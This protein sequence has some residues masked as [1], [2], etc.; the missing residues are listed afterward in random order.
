MSMTVS[1]SNGR[2][3]ILHDVRLEISKNVDEGL[4][5]NDVVFIDKLAKFGH[6]VTAYT[7]AKFQPYID[8]F[9]IGK[10]NCRQIHET[11]TEH[12]AKENEKLIAKAE[13]NKRKG[14]K[15]SVRKP[16]KL[17]HEY[18]LQFGNREDNSTLR[19]EN[20]TEEQYSKR[21]LANRDGCREALEK[22]KEKYPHVDILLAAFHADEPNGTPHMHII[23]QFEG[24]GYQKGLSHQISIS[25]ALELD[26]FERSGNRG[27]YSI[28]RWTRDIADNILAPLL[29]KHFS[30]N[31]EVLGEHRKH[32]DIVFFREK[33]KAEARALREER[34]QTQKERKLMQDTLD[35]ISD[36]QDT[37]RQAEEIISRKEQIINQARAQA[38]KDAEEIKE[39]AKKE[40]KEE[41]DLIIAKAREKAKEIIDNAIKES[42]KLIHG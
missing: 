25:K 39:T 5:K 13:E 22:I 18:V 10:K 34:E 26:G 30:Q 27:D 37:I 31:R 6:D 4:I 12:I 3:A 40:A 11:Y 7:D 24:E 19:M 20:E 1:V 9:N 36:A 15:R 42:S 17:C 32:V 8:E 16:T 29:E 35:K 38:D 28:N 41:C 21:I 23:I 14:I 33:A 2:I